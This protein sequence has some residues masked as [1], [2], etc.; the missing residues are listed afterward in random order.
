MQNMQ[1]IRGMLTRTG[2]GDHCVDA[3]IQCCN[4]NADYCSWIKHSGTHLSNI[5]VYSIMYGGVLLRIAG[6]IVT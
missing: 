1:Y 2:F 5:V 6:H 3:L 4:C